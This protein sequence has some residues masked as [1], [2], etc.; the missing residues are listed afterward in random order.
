VD[1][2]AATRQGIVV[3]NAPDDCT[4]DV[5][6]AA[7]ALLLAGARRAPARTMAS[8]GMRILATDPAPQASAVE[9]GV[10]R[11]E[12]LGHHRRAGPH[13]RPA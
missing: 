11:N 9:A 1:L 10:A 13:L 5:S 12:E 4:E 6:D 3:C 7:A 2:E 8:F